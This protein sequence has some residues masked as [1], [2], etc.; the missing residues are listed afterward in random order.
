MSTTNNEGTYGLKKD[1][2][3][4][5]ETFAQ[6][7]A[8]IAPSGTPTVV[9]PLVFALAGA[10]TWFA[11]LF[12]TIAVLFVS[13]N[14]KEF[15]KDSA[16][17][18]SFYIYIVKGLGNRVGVIAG[19]V[20]FIA[21]IA[22]A[23]SV[24][25]GFTNYFNVLFAYFGLPHI[26]E[27]ILTAVV[28]GLAWF[29]AFKD[30][31]LSTRVALILE[32]SSVALILILLFITL[33]IHGFKID[34][35]QLSLKGVSFD[36][37]RLGL[38]LAI[39]SFTGF[40]SAAT[41]GEEAKNPL[42]T[43]PRVLTI[44]VIAIGALFVFS[45]Y[46][47]TLGF[48]GN[49]QTLGQSTAPFNVLAKKAHVSFFI[50]LIALGTVVSF[51]ACV[52]ASINA[53]AR[54]IFHMSR[55]GLFHS[56]IGEAHEKNETP[57]KA[58]TISAIVTFIPAAVLILKGFGPFDIYGLVGTI[59]TLAFIVAYILVSVA[60]PVYLFHNKKLKLKNILISAAS[61]I[62]LGVAIV[63]SV[64]P[65][66]PAPLNYLP[67]IFL[68]IIVLGVVWFFIAKKINPE[69]GQNIKTDVKEIDKQYKSL[70]SSNL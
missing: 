67:Y 22:C 47:E 28:V 21:Y 50:P 69:I 68:G 30:I 15:A 20:L 54:I 52:L 49:A 56:S 7:V 34:F 48:T 62:F 37:I 5:I 39:F 53:G 35:D 31:K 8:N 10:G 36:S 19:W 59:A 9:I 70:D 27:L 60:A 43:I 18:G 33:W 66:P 63:G 16:S 13:L 41:L 24:T 26:S 65:V 17:P 32:F 2:L 11:Y 38:V 51:F 57:A 42:K 25:G 55:H 40:E 4:P 3:S 61:I 1:S 44:S 23:S 6:S 46:T 45:S 12:A 14:I 29:V 58:I 64:Y